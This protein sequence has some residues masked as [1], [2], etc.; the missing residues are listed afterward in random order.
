MKIP[1]DSELLLMQPCQAAQIIALNQYH[2]KLKPL[3]SEIKKRIIPVLFPKIQEYLTGRKT[4][5]TFE[6]LIQRHYWIG[7]SPKPGFN[8][9]PAFQ[10]PNA[11][12]FPSHFEGVEEELTEQAMI[13]GRTQEEIGEFCG[14][15][16]RRL[17]LYDTDRLCT[18][19]LHG[20][21]LFPKIEQE[22]TFLKLRGFLPT[23][24]LWIEI[25]R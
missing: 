2:N 25:D 9:I 19:L 3:I 6:Q 22:L 24:H 10:S 5:L 20:R 7:T 12:L 11:L 14:E 1:T 4:P 18:S 16:I 21:A 13:F 23:P 8:H 15:G 17:Q